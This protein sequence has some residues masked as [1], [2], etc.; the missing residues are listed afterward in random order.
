MQRSALWPAALLGVFL[1]GCATVGRD[2][3]SDAVTR[4]HLN[5]TTQQEIL[6][7][8]GPPWR[9]G[10]DDGLVTWTYGRYRYSLFRSARTKDLVVRFDDRGI[11]VSYTY[12]TTV[13]AK[14]FR[15]PRES[16]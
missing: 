8:L 16:P 1:A 5:Q 6:D 11:V 9:T 14:E 2:F 10:I 13:D 12:N 3:S 15:P 4:I 7:L